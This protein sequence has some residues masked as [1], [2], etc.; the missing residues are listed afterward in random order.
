[1]KKKPEK[2]LMKILIGF[3]LKRDHWENTSLRLNFPV[4]SRPYDD[5]ELGFN[6]FQMLAHLYILTVMNNQ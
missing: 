2:R 4:T 6:R 3:F 5:L 1:M